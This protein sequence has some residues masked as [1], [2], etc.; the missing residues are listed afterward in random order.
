MLGVVEHGTAFGA[1]HALT[2]PDGSFATIAGKTG[3]GDNRVERYAPG[4][5]VIESKVRNR[6]AAFVFTIGDHFFGTLLV[7]TQEPHAA[8]KSYTSALAVRVFRNLAPSLKPLLASD[9]AVQI[10]R[11]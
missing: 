2:L 3:T 7:Y 8:S 1:Y 10:A 5:A 9:V 6:T 4:G 11:K